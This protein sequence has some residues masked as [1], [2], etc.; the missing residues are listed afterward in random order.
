MLKLAL[1]YQSCTA[2]PPRDEY[3]FGNPAASGPRRHAREA[4][5]V[6]CAKVFVP[7]A[8]LCFSWGERVSVEACST[9]AH[10]IRKRLAAPGG[11]QGASALLRSDRPLSPYLDDPGPYPP[12]ANRGAQ[13]RNGAIDS[14]FFGADRPF[15]RPLFGL[16][17]SQPTTRYRFAFQPPARNE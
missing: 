17:K 2:K 7:P 12:D 4:S 11:E 13:Q 3:S 1:G 6:V 16:L 14:I 9:A 5:N 8:H 10:R 15:G